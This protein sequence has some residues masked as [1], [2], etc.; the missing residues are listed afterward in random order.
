M[1][2]SAQ[3]DV[4][5]RSSRQPTT[6]AVQVRFTFMGMFCKYASVF[7]IAWKETCIGTACERWLFRFCASGG[8]FPE[9]YFFQFQPLILRG[10]LCFLLKI[11]KM[12]PQPI[13]VNIATQMSILFVQIMANVSA[14]WEHAVRLENSSTTRK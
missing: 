11:S 12:F 9:P 8:G 7:C 10:S 5:I 2:T 1:D 14:R 13:I 6:A 4:I 3:E